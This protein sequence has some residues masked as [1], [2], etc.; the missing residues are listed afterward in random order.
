MTRDALAYHGCSELFQVWSSSPQYM[1]FN[2]N[3][4]WMHLKLQS[5][6]YIWRVDCLSVGFTS[7]LLG[8]LL[9]KKQSRKLE[10]IMAVCENNG[11]EWRMWKHVLPLIM[12]PECDSPN[13]K[14]LEEQRIISS[15]NSFSSYL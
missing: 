9:K 10:P 5:V 15:F 1:I 13:S 6:Q 3:C 8:N 7:E 12:F 14:C 4:V 11:L 2:L